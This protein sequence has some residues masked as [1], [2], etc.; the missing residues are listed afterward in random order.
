[1]PFKHFEVERMK[2]C[3][4]T[5]Q[6]SEGELERVCEMRKSISSVNIFSYTLSK[7]YY[8]RHLANDRN[9]DIFV[10][11]RIFPVPNIIRR[12]AFFHCKVSIKYPKEATVIRKKIDVSAI[13]CVW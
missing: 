2:C 10:P 7:L 5:K 9:E 11:S 12:R 1:M 3:G 4:E 8:E 13:L 6:L